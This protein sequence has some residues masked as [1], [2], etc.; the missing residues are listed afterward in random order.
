MPEKKRRTCPACGKRRLPVDESGHC[1][2]CRQV[3]E[4]WLSGP[5][6]IYVAEEAADGK[7]RLHPLGRRESNTN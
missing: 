1:K 4:Q 7:T 2:S 3:F 6:G 5:P